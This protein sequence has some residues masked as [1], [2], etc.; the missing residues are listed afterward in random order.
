MKLLATNQVFEV[1]LGESVTTTAPTYDIDA[2]EVV[3]ATLNLITSASTA[4]T[5]SFTDSYATACAAPGAN[6]QKGITRIHI[7]N[8][9][10]IAH[11]FFLRRNIAGSTFSFFLP[12]TTLQPGEFAEYEVGQGWTFFDAAGN[13]K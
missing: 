5:G 8:V 12:G 4:E 2:A 6:N 11:T 9:D 10:T 3:S 1:K 13:Q 7:A